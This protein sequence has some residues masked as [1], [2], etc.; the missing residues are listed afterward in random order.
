MTRRKVYVTVSADHEPDGKCCPKSIRLAH[1]RRYEFDKVL[2][3]GGGHG[4]LPGGNS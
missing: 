2:R 4:W 1:G 3:E